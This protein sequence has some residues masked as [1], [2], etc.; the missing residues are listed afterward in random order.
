L[1]RFLLVTPE[2]AQVNN[3][4]QPQRQQRG[5]DG[6]NR[7]SRIPPTA[8]PELLYSGTTTVECVFFKKTP[9]FATLK[10]ARE[11]WNRSI[12]AENP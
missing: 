12:S 1:V 9:P 2:A 3:K 10:K 8:V 4:L 7:R 6:G 5:K 11:F